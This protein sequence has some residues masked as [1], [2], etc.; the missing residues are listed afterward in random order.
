MKVRVVAQCL[1]N[2]LI[3]QVDY[4]RSHRSPSTIPRGTSN[5]SPRKSLLRVADYTSPVA[6]DIVPGLG[7]RIPQASRID[8]LH[9]SLRLGFERCPISHRLFGPLL[10]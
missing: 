8:L 3:V 10:V 2:A 6:L 5:W 7:S 1:V 9:A 4:F